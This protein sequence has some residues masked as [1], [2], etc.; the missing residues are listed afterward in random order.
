LYSSD[1]VFDG[2]VARE[3]VSPALSLAFSFFQSLFLRALGGAAEQPA[4]T[5]AGTFL[6]TPGGR[7][8]EQSLHR[9]LKNTIHHSLVF[10]D[11]LVGLVFIQSEFANHVTDLFLNFKNKFIQDLVIFQSQIKSRKR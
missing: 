1:L 7:G 4:T 5:I 8:R 9:V 10:H 3:E 2:Q 11:M 6:S